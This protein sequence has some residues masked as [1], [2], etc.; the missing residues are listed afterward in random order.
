LKNS[1][2]VAMLGFDPVGV[3]HGEGVVGEVGVV[4]RWL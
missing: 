1:K 2:L 3:R 4:E